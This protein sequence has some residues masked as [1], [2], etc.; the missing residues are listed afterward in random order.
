MITEAEVRKEFAE[1]EELRIAAG[2]E[3]VHAT[4][5]SMFVFLGLELEELQYVALFLHP[6]L[7]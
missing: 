4:S 5:P 3:S 2:E 7:F 1:D 6:A